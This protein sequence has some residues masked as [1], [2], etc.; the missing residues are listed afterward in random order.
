[1]NPLPVRRWCGMAWLDDVRRMQQFA[2]LAQ[3]LTFQAESLN[4]FVQGIQVRSD[5]LEVAPIR[6]K[7]AAV[8]SQRLEFLLKG[9][10]LVQQLAMSVEER[11][12]RHLNRL[13]QPCYSVGQSQRPASLLPVSC[14]LKERVRE[15]RTGAR[16]QI[17]RDRTPAAHIP[18][19]SAA[20]GC[21]I[22]INKFTGGKLM[23]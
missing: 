7:V 2:S 19:T 5:F 22:K 23:P 11:I 9:G 14:G 8:A 21:A 12:G 6:W 16:R 17:A 15:G 1:M 20:H 4:V 10:M 13:H 18:P 3:P